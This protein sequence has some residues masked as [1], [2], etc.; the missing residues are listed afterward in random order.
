MLNQAL[1][2]EQLLLPMEQ[3]AG[4][5]LQPGRTLERREKP[6]TAAENRTKSYIRVHGRG[7]GWVTLTFFVLSFNLGTRIKRHAFKQT[8]NSSSKSPH[9]LKE[10][11]LNPRSKPFNFH[12][13]N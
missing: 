13:C 5:A 2:H 10:I 11:M 12:G 4:C 7:A 3:G 6:L 8:N 1:R 9:I